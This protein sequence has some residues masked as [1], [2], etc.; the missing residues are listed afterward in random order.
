MS[1]CCQPNALN[2]RMRLK[3]VL[4]SS[5]HMLA[6]LTIQVDQLATELMSRMKTVTRV[7]SGADNQVC[8]NS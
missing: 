1:K 2:A 3:K 6:Q 4:Q 8:E 5:R 7:C